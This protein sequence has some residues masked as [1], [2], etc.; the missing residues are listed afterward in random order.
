MQNA[1]PSGPRPIKDALQTLLREVGL[2]A[3]SSGA[4]RVF[5]AWTQAVG[6]KL[7]QRA[8][9]VR[10]RGGELQVEVDSS[11]HLQELENFTGDNYRAGANRRLGAHVI[12]RVTFKLKA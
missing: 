10:F 3:T 12:Q 5:E 1:T 2:R 7:A 9:P 8:V 11:A 4:S 6:A